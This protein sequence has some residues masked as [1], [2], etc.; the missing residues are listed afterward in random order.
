MC[1]CSTIKNSEDEKALLGQETIVEYVAN[2]L[3]YTTDVTRY[4]LHKHESVFKVRVTKIKDILDYLFNEA[5]YTSHH[6]AQNPR[7]LCHSLRTT[8]QRLCELKAHGCI[9]T[10]LV[11]VC[12][13][14]NEYQKFL[15]TWIDVRKKL[16]AK[17]VDSSSD[18]DS[19]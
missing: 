4:I 14:T 2:R 16:S 9:P 19:D 12:R 7:I 11:V 13:S 5:G 17:N 18:S 6:V 8:K 15:N 3:G 10:S 1:V